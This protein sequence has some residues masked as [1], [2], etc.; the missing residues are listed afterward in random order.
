[1]LKKEKEEKNSL[2]CVDDAIAL[3]NHKS[4]NKEDVNGYTLPRINGMSHKR[5]STVLCLTAIAP[6]F[7]QKTVFLI[8]Q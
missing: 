1:M 6:T 7:H 8:R 3:V 5:K 2:E 4:S